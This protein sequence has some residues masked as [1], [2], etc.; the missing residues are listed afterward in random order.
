MS[1]LGEPRAVLVTGIQAAGKT[2]IGR[3][4]AERLPRAAFVEGD[5]LWQMVVSGR[6]DM[7]GE[8]DDEARRQL[9]LRYR[10]G[11]NLARSFVEAGFVAVHADN[12]YGADVASWLDWV[13]VPASVVVLRPDPRVV[14]QRDRERGSPAYDAWLGDGTELIDA[15]RMFDGWLDDIPPV[16]IRVDSSELGEE[17]TVDEILARWDEATVI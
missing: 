17:Q 11:A 4:L 3:R 6:R 9:E 8:A 16:G 1:D 10:N 14:A 15:V 7:S 13:A 12:V 5:L 2:T